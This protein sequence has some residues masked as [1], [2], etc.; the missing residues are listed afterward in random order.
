LFLA[1]AAPAQTTTP[2]KAAPAAGAKASK[3][4]GLTGEYGIMASELKL[5]DE[6][7]ATLTSRLEA[8]ATAIKEWNQNEGKGLPDLEKALKDATVAKDKAK[9]A[10]LSKQIKTLTAPREALSQK[11]DKEI[12]AVLTHQQA[13][14]WEGF[15]A[16]RTLMGAT[17]KANLTDDQK[18]T[19]KDKAIK[20]G[21]QLLNAESD[22]KA[23]NAV[24][25]ELHDWVSK[26]VLTPEQRTALLP[27]PKAAGAAD[28]AKAPAPK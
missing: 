17:A 25:K 9:A 8:K 13:E 15:K 19:I 7:V 3:T 2:A 12:A 1:T 21:P 11:Y 14:N 28:P 4:K 27:P 26:D 10:D 18:A 16:Y 6:Q 23:K 5:S 22:T 20:T 24:L